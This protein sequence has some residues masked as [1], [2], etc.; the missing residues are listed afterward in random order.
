M[1]T[2]LPSYTDLPRSLPI[3]RSYEDILQA[4]PGSQTPAEVVV[5]GRDVTAPVYQR[6]SELAQQKALATGLCSS[7]STSSSTRTGR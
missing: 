7:R 3:V 5:E 2:K 6:V 4:F 1:H